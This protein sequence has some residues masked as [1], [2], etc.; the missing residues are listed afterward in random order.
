MLTTQFRLMNKVGEGGA[1]GGAGGGGGEG[2]DGKGDDKGGSGDKSGEGGF[3]KDQQDYLSKTINAAMTNFVKRQ[4]FTS[5]IQD[6][7]KGALGEAMKNFKPAASNDDGEDGKNKDDGNHDDRKDRSGERGALA[8]QVKKL[9]DIVDKQTKALKEKDD[10]AAKE[11]EDRDRA[12]EKNALTKALLKNRISEGRAAAAAALLIHEQKRV[13]RNDAG[14][15]GIVLRR[16]YN[17]ETV[18]EWLPVDK[19]VE[20]WSKTAEGKEF[21]PSTD[22][23][24]SGNRGGNAG[25]RRPGD[26]PGVQ[27]ALMAIGEAMMS[28]SLGAPEKG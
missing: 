15:I 8:L 9:Q 18:D 14:E 1:G 19:G 23:G 25:Q 16:T 27:S 4:S 7:V 20:E 26:K 22:V 17:N 5:A 10:Q 3:S 13:K 21:L 6:T 28:G 24:G 12:E 11:R 2:G